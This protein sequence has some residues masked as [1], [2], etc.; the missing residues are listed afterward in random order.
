MADRETSTIF[1]ISKKN[2][3]VYRVTG[4]ENQAGARDG[5]LAKALFNKPSSLA[6]YYVNPVKI[7]QEND[8][9]P[10]YIENVDWFNC[11]FVNKNNFTECGFEITRST[12]QK[13]IKDYNSVKYITDYEL[14]AEDR[15]WR[16]LD[17]YTVDNRT[18]F[19]ADKENHCIRRIIIK[20]CK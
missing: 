10:V 6:V 8:L 5:N 4:K 20:N 7:K 2:N 9:F 15:D 1:F 16:Y 11:T 14:T 3:A 12:D 17:E 18:I 19:V 13:L